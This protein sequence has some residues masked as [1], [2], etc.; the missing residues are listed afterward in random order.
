MQY[1]KAGTLDRH[2]YE[3][4]VHSISEVMKASGFSGSVW[5]E[6]NFT[7]QSVLDVEV[8]NKVGHSL[9]HIGDNIFSIGK[10]IGPVVDRYPTS[11]YSD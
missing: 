10:K 7:E 9:A 5:T 2:N 4:S 11:I 8:L 1:R 6:D 3:Y